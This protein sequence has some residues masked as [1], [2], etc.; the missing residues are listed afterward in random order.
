[1][2]GGSIQFALGMTTVTLWRRLV[3]RLSSRLASERAATLAQAQTRSLVSVQCGIDRCP[4]APGPKE[5]ASSKPWSLW[6][7]EGGEPGRR[8]LGGELQGRGDLPRPT[9]PGAA[10]CGGS[11]WAPSCCAGQWEVSLW[12]GWPQAGRPG[13]GH[14]LSTW[15]AGAVSFSGRTLRSGPLD[16]GSDLETSRKLIVC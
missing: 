13:W 1:M 3:L 2:G 10:L 14:R 12:L 6:Y 4:E 7:P 8:R 11:G 16:D 5:G 15:A 9:L